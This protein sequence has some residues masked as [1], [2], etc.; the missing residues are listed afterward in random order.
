M[1]FAVDK[2]KKKQKKGRKKT[3]QQ[4]Q[5]NKETFSLLT[6]MYANCLDFVKQYDKRCQSDGNVVQFIWDTQEYKTLLFLYYGRVK[7]WT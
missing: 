3:K 2:C 4:Q 1:H 5:P 7:L 6:L